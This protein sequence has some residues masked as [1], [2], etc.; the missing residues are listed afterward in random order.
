LRGAVAR[1][2]SGIVFM[3]LPEDAAGQR[4]DRVVVGN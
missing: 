1:L 3:N 4:R 2:F